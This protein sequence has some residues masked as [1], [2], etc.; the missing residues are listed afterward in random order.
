MDVVLVAMV[1]LT[2]LASLKFFELLL[3]SI[4]LPAWHASRNTDPCLFSLPLRTLIH[5]PCANRPFRI[6]KYASLAIDTVL[7]SHDTRDLASLVTPLR[8]ACHQASLRKLPRL[9]L[10][11]PVD[12]AA[13]PESGEES[14]TNWNVQRQYAASSAP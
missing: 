6:L 10:P 9:L 5:P 3:G 13:V 7:F 12:V 2:M 14:R 11:A 1:R 8:S 4:L